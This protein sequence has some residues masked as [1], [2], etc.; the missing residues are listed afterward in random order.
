MNNSEIM[1]HSASHVLAMAVL[2]LYP[3]AKLAIGPAIEDGFYYDFALPK[4]ISDEDLPK[5]EKEMGKL[6]AKKLPF[7]QVFLK[8]GEAKKLYKNNP[9]KQELLDEIGGDKI[10]FYETN[11]FR[12]L[13]RGPHISDTGKVGAFKLT[14]TAGAYW[15]GDE[16][17]PMLTRIYGVAFKTQKELEKHLALLEEAKNRD[18]RKIGKE[19]NLFV[20][21]DLVGKGLPLLTP[22]GSVIRRE[23]ERF[24]VDEE[25]KRGY[26]HVYT[27]DLARVDL[28]K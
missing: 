19:Q 27:P 4:P 2:K 9:F 3:E 12:D 11:G 10:S 6:V 23:L 15:R 24:I 22:K 17:K 1:R 14:R 21:T 26:L 28:Y 8:R 13:C 5:I 25:L 16:K 20:F 18:H 7:K